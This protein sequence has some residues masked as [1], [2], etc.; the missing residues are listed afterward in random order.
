M[1]P[2]INTILSV[3]MKGEI[4]ACV[5]ECVIRVTTSM[6]KREKVVIVHQEKRTARVRARVRRTRCAAK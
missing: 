1:E 3:I 2:L 5:V 4:L 6:V